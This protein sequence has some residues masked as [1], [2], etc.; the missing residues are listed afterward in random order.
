MDPNSSNL[1]VEKKIPSV[2]IERPES[3]ELQHI[4]KQQE[5]RLLRKVYVAPVSAILK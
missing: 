5:A 1:D 2:A 3:S 4:D